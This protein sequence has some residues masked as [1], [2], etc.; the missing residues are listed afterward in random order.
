M[1]VLTSKWRGSGARDPLRRRDSRIEK[2]IGREGLLESAVKL[3]ILVM[4]W[5][6]LC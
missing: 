3:L 5:F 2:Y 4:E 6:R 1:A